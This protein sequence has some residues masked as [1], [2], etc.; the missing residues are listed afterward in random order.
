MNSRTYESAF[1]IPK[2]G[3]TLLSL[4]SSVILLLFLT[5]CGGG[6]SSTPSNVG[7]GY[8]LV[9]SGGTLND[10]STPNGLIVLAT[11]RDSQGRGPGA[12]AGWTVTITGPGINTTP[13]SYDDGSTSSYITWLWD[14]NI[15]EPKTGSYTARATNGSITLTYTFTIDASSTISPPA[16]TKTGDTIYWSPVDGAGSYYYRV[17]DSFGTVADSDYLS[18]AQT[19]FVLKTLPNGDYLI[20]VFAHTKDRKA[21]MNDASASP[22]LPSQENISVG[23][24]LLPVSGAGSGYYLDARSG[25]LYEGQDGEGTHHYGLAIWTSILTSTGGNPPA[26]GWNVVVTGPGLPPANETNALKF[27]YPAN[28]SNYIYWNFG[29]VPA[30]GLYTVT[31]TT[32]GYTLTDS[33][34]IPNTTAKLPVATGLAVTRAQNG[35]Y[36]V[37]WDSIMGASSYYVNVWTCVGGINTP[38]GCNG[39]IYSEIASVWVNSTAATILKTSLTNGLVYDVYVTASALDMTTMTVTPPPTPGTQVD[40]SDTTFTYVTFTAQ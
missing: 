8:T 36:N 14:G 23:T 4:L 24:F 1:R 21:L 20:E 29:F 12:A 10:E 39:G 11:L 7:G 37:A 5:S 6:G 38:T 32:T 16:L 9:A 25:V 22:A 3:H 31:A 15:I 27:T 19:S 26:G 13:E 35:D 18:A 28:K 34:T 2:F 40:M 30:A 17:K 33:F